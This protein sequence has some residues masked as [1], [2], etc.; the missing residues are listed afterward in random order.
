MVND[1]LWERA[2]SISKE[3]GRDRKDI[4]RELIGI[5]QPPNSIEGSD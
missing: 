1:K 4:Y 3:T 5:Q 2:K